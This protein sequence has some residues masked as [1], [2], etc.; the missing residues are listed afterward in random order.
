MDKRIIVDCLSYFLI[1]LISSGVPIYLFHRN[2]LNKILGSI[3]SVVLTL[4]LVNVNF[5]LIHKLHATLSPYFSEFHE[6]FWI[7][8]PLFV[9]AY[10]L[11]SEKKH[12]LKSP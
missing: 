3:I 4:I 2:K 11:Y 10:C 5:Y 8:P 7:I 12:K 1:F 9:F 6:I